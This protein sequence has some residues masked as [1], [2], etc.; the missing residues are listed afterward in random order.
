M[1]L[2]GQALE[3]DPRLARVHSTRAVVY[4][5]AAIFS[6]RPAYEAFPQ[7]RESAQMALSLDDTVAEAHTILA[8]IAYGYD[9]RWDDAERVFDL[10]LATG[11]DD[12]GT[13]MRAS[14]FHAAS[15][16]AGGH[17]EARAIQ[18]MRRAMEL[19][20]LSGWE[21]FEA[22]TI[23]WLLRRNDD[24][25]VPLQEAV[26]FAPQHGLSVMSLAAVYRDLG[27][28]AE[29]IPMMEHALTLT[30]RNPLVLTNA[31]AMYAKAGNLALAGTIADELVA[32]SAKE[33]VAPY[34]VAQALGWVGRMEDAF[35]WLDR[36][37][38]AHDFWL[39]M[40]RGD[41]LSDPLR[42]DSRFSAMMRRVGIPS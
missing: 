5:Y 27:R 12:A 18:L 38:E 13:L 31:V 20:P 21:R 32:R 23:L 15:A 26:E 37:V 30:R 36:A 40:A 25:L 16:G 41:Q 33:W 28:M 1:A 14:L 10:A 39:V 29:A 24:A 8:Q 3:R 4:T 42:D 22:G 17:H 6:F 35:A 11:P 2:L 7:A 34:Y 19:E 9:W